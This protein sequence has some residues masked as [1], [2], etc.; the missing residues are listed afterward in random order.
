MNF[1][2]ILYNIKYNYKLIKKADLSS[3]NN[4]NNK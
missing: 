4:N 2:Q 3:F 1:F